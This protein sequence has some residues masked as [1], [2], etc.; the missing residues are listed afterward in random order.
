MNVD[1]YLEFVGDSEA[2]MNYHRWSYITCAAAAL[3]R[4][5]Y[6]DFGPIGILYPN[7]YTL[8]V[9]TPGTRKDTAINLATRILKASGYRTFSPTKSTRERFLSDFEEGAFAGRSSEDALAD[10]LS[11]KLTNRARPNDVFI[12]VG[13]LID[14]IGAKNSAFIN[15]LTVL[16]ECQEYYEDKFRG[17]KGVHIKKP[18]TNLLGGITPTSLAAAMPADIIGQ[19]FTSRIVTVFSDPT[20]KRI[21]FPK[22]QSKDKELKLIAQFKELRHIKGEVKFSKPAEQLMEKI[23]V[24]GK[25]P[26]DVRFHYFF[27]R[28]QAHLIKLAM[29]LAACSGDLIIDEDI[30]IQANTILTWTEIT[31]SKAFGEFGEAKNARATHKIMEYIGS[32]NEPIDIR[33]L[34]H[35]VSSD[36]DKI[37]VLYEIIENL[38]QAGK[39]MKSTNADNKEFVILNRSTDITKLP[40]IDISYIQEANHDRS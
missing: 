13:E 27:A 28:R 17:N 21:A 18:T 22:P 6:F 19:G 39:I 37:S 15:T 4:N 32:Y 36:V 23:Y 11:A 40:G 20:G 10:L 9:G 1:D 35:T 25:P 5:I 29:V 8:L 2:P 30:L 34:W 14:F 26:A 33:S 31:M 24:E 7:M 38:C 16:W 12:A 3:S